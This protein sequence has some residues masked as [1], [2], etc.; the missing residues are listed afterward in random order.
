MKEKSYTILEKLNYY[1]DTFTRLPFIK[2]KDLG[3]TSVSLISSILNY[4]LALLLLGNDTTDELSL[5]SYKGI[6]KDIINAWNVDEAFFKHLQSNI[7]KSIFLEFSKLEK[8]TVES[9]NRL[10]LSDS[11]LVVPIDARVEEGI[12]RLGFLI[13]AEPGLDCEPDIDIMALEIIGGLVTGAITNYFAMQ[14]L[15]KANKGMEAEIIDRQT[16]EKKLDIE[17]SQLLSIFDS[18]NEV[19]YVADPHTYE[20]LF[21][22]KAIQNLF[23]TKLVGELCYKALQNLESPCNFCT[24]EIILKQKDKAYRWEFYNSFVKKHF[25]LVDRII[26]WTDGRDVRFELGIDITQLKQAEEEKRVLERQLQQAQKMEAIGLLAGGIAHDFNNILGGIIGFAELAKYYIEKNSKAENKIDQLLHTTERAKD[27]VKQILAFSYQDKIEKKP[28]QLKIVVKEIIKFLRASLPSTIEIRQNIS[29]DAGAII[30]EPTQ[31]YQ[32]LVNL[33]TNAAYAMKEGG[34]LE[35]NLENA[36][37]DAETASQYPEIE[38]GNYVKLFV[39]DTG[40]G[41]EKEVMERIFDPYFTTKAEGVGTGL[42]LSVVHGIVKSHGGIINVHSEPMK[43]T[44]FQLLFP[45]IDLEAAEEYGPFE[46][47][48]TGNECILS[49]DDDFVVLNANKEMME[50][51]GYNVIA[52]TSSNEA[53]ET[54]RAQPDKF[55]LVIT[56]QTMPNMTGERLAKEIMRIRTDIPIIICTGFSESINEKKAKAIG[57]RAF[58]MK[59]VV[60]R[61]LAET[62]RDV[63][64]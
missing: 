49:V 24:N 36:E 15:V 6:D 31:I 8:S 51:L 45:V 56:D 10:G 52:K 17:R 4:R 14:D 55:D 19:V 1:S 48:P 3:E 30:G 44:T 11:C 50:V 28:L 47:F 35:I 32:V 62:I 38:P 39:G 42:G 22:N 61:E 21:V 58:L 25:I 23:A 34:V 53:L 20:I 13:A 27:L 18:L 9:A 63:L 40:H 5:L 7:N 29:P 26:K 57:I 16:A 12:K 37:V 2:L 43:G 33:C 60:M 64:T 54:F 59:P 46:S 41:M